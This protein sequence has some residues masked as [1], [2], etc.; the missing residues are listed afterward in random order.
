MSP[1]LLG[2]SE[3]TVCDIC[4]FVSFIIHAVLRRDGYFRIRGGAGVEARTCER[5]KKWAERWKKD[6]FLKD[7]KNIQSCYLDVGFEYNL[8]ETKVMVLAYDCSYFY[9]NRIAD[10]VLQMG[11]WCNAKH[12]E[13]IKCGMVTTSDGFMLDFC[14]DQGC[15]SD[16]K[17]WMGT[18]WNEDLYFEVMKS[19]FKTPFVIGMDKGMDSLDFFHPLIKRLAPAKRKKMDNAELNRIQQNMAFEISSSRI[20]IEQIFSRNIRRET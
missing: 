4:H 10:W 11:Y 13:C 7:L 19:D 1:I 18:S 16:T 6:L 20:A 14:L 17:V 3:S 2:I 15:C 12:R 5:T 8:E 9:M